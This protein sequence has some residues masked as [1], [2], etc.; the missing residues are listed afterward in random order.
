M[1][2]KVFVHKATDQ[3]EPIALCYV[4]EAAD[5]NAGGRSPLA[6]LKHPAFVPVHHSHF[7]S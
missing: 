2:G 7:R 4:H 6:N 3:G 1:Y 5:I